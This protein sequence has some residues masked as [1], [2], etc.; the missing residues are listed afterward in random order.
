[1]IIIIIVAITVVLYAIA[2]AYIAYTSHKIKQTEN[3]I[4][5]AKNLKKEIIHDILKSQY[6]YS[7]QISKKI[8]ELN[9]VR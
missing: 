5:S 4:V 9:R 2:G 3:S 6:S 1:M 7:E 8:K